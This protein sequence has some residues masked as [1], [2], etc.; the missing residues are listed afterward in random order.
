MHKVFIG[1]DKLH[2]THFDLHAIDVSLETIDGNTSCVIC[3]S[4]SLVIN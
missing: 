3:P 2:E 4:F 1:Q